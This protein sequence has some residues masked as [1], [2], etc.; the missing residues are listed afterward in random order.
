MLA[1]VYTFLFGF[2]SGEDVYV[3]CS[4]CLRRKA[5]LQAGLNALLGWPGIGFFLMPITVGQ[6]VATWVRGPSKDLLAAQAEKQRAEENMR[7]QSREEHLR[8]LRDP[9]H[10]RLLLASAT[11]TTDGLELTLERES[12]ARLGLGLVAVALLLLVFL[13]F[14]T[15]PDPAALAALSTSDPTTFAALVPFGVGLLAFGTFPLW[16]LAREVRRTHVR[17]VGDT[18]EVVI[19]RRLGRTRW[20]TPLETL[21]CIEPLGHGL[22]FVADTTFE[23]RGLGLTRTA[24]SLAPELTKMLR[25]SPDSLPT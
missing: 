15:R 12:P 7:R 22:R 9:A 23:A 8:V 14:E 20:C 6:N 17:T 10:A 4:P 21:E 18:L 25:P 16:V 1:H 24:L 19:D 11:R 13:A 2:V 3:G 5:L